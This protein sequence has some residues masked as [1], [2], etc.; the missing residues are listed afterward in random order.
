MDIRSQDGLSLGHSSGHGL[1]AGGAQQETRFCSPWFLAQHTRAHTHTRIRTHTHT[2]T[3]TPIRTHACKH[4][5]TYAHTHTH[6]HPYAHMH[7]STRTRRH[8]D[9]HASAPTHLMK[10]RLAMSW[11]A[12]RSSM[13]ELRQDCASTAICMTLVIITSRSFTPALKLLKSSCHLHCS[14]QRGNQS[15]VNCR[16]GGWCGRALSM[17]TKGHQEAAVTAS[18]I[19]QTQTEHSHT[20]THMHARSHA[21]TASSIQQTQTAF[22]HTHTRTHTPLQSGSHARLQRDC[23]GFHPVDDTLPGLLS[24]HCTS[25]HTCGFA[26]THTHTHTHTHV[27]TLAC[28]CTHTHTHMYARSHARA[29][30]HTHT[31]IHKHTC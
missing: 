8:A 23:V 13:R 10:S 30:T 22:S 16:V 14:Q 15:I 31:R 7:A 17:S 3:H 6:T 12:S 18:S 26:H 2:H 24:M 25:K 29:H 19:Q 5:H 11:K 1:R 9:T 4:T 21:V 27:R 20:H 28:P